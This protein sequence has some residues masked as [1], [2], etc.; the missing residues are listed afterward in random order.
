MMV[1]RGKQ[2]I[3]L[4]KYKIA[5]DKLKCKIMSIIVIF[6]SFVF[7]ENEKI[8]TGLSVGLTNPDRTPHPVYLPIVSFS[9]YFFKSIGTHEIS[10]EYMS[11]TNKTGADEMSYRWIG[12]GYTFLFEMPIDYL[13]VGPMIGLFNFSYQLNNPSFY[14]IPPNIYSNSVSGNGIYFGGC[15]IAVVLGEDWIRFKIQNRILFG[16][17]TVNGNSKFD[18]IN[19]LDISILFAYN[20]I[21]AP[22][23]FDF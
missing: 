3:G 6:A 10:V 5:E 13:F 22:L 9:E 11:M 18:A 16:S 15:K 7:A 12:L 23:I 4:E 19:I 21:K 14:Y 17:S 8:G 20:H 1:F 2:R